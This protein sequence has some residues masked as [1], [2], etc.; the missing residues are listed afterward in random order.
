MIAATYLLFAMA[1]LGAL[2]ILLFHTIAHGIRKNPDSRAELWPHALR[3]PT[4]AILFIAIPNFALDGAWYWTLLALLAIDLAIS[5]WD[6]ALERESR[7]VLGGLPTG[8]YVLHI[9]LAMTFGALVACILGFEGSRASSPT[10]IHFEP[11]SVPDV[12]R[13]ALA[14]AAPI[15]LGSGLLD[16]LAALRLARTSRAERLEDAKR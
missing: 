8:E 16:A 2:D 4:Y 7:R 3:G 11:V 1:V 6:F 14:I 10:R 5:I 15:V 12:I 13:L 9:L